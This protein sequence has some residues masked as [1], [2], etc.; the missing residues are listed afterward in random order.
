[1]YM[2]MEAQENDQRGGV[3][4]GAFIYMWGGVPETTF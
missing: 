1:M 4:W 2:D 3:P